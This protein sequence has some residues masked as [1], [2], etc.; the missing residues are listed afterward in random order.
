[1]KLANIK[2]D[3]SA[4]KLISF[5]GI[6]GAFKKTQA[7][8]LTEFLNAQKQ[9]AKLYSF[10]LYEGTYYGKMIGA[11]LRGEYGSINEVNP[12]LAALLFALDRNELQPELTQNTTNQIVSVCDRYVFSNIAHQCS[13]LNSQ[14]E[15]NDLEKWIQHLEFEKNQ[16]PKPDATIFLKL[17]PELARKTIQTKKARSYTTAKAD[18]HE[19]STTHLNDS[20][21]IYESLAE[22]NNWITINCNDGD[23]IKSTL[24]IHT[25]VLEALNFV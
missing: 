13:K 10:P 19:A 17:P 23:N 1:M 4:H 11:Y 22:R 25:E 15:I 8:K 21:Q 2:K 12:K 14:K 16:L 5:E 18:I 24:E 20:F 6:D 3:L 9:P 7:L